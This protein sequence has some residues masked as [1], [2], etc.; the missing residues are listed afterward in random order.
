MPIRLA[1]CQ[2]GR[3]ARNLVGTRAWELFSV[4]EVCL[5][6]GLPKPITSIKALGL[7]TNTTYFV[8]IRDPVVQKPKKIKLT[9][10]SLINQLPW[11][12]GSMPECYAGV[13]GSFLP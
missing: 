10:N 2:F 6:I 5:R 11:P 4:F 3:N 13:P 7:I 1:D 9:N 8:V 12:N